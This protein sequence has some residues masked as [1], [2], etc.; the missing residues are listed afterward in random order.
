MNVEERTS[1]L[2]A[3]AFVLAAAAITVI[4]TVW[5]TGGRST[6]AMTSYS[7]LFDR[8]VSG[9]T[10]G[11]PVRYLGVDV[12]DVAAMGLVSD[13]GTRVSVEVTVAATTP[14]H[15]G[16]YASLAYLGITGVAFINLAADPG[17][18]PP[19]SPQP[20]GEYPVIA[21]RD[22]GLAALFAQSGDITSEVS[23]LLDQANNLLGEDNRASLTR[24]LANVE[25][26]SETL[27]GE[28]EQMAALPQRMNLALDDLR[29]MVDQVRGLITEAQPGVLAVTEQL[30][31]ATADVAALTGRLDGWFQ[32]NE[33]S[34]DSF[35]EA[36]LGELPR[37]IAE[38]RGT[39]RELD[40][41]LT[42][43]REDPSQLI[44]QPERT[45]VQVEP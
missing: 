35:V 32:N 21:T 38:T 29:D 7:V 34:L 39:L 15:Q 43:V 36:G 41:L 11:S 18:F 28:R 16:T 4:F 9:L 26:L 24:T 42:D 33:Q 10:P 31:Q 27:V 23:M 25:L 3:G 37:L 20:G 40:K 14:I 45:A 19:L 44:Y 6:E 2:I 17:E 5:I 12:G 30:D 22:V 8:D 1:Y 13:Q